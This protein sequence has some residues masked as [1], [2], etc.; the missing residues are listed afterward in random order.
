MKRAAISLYTFT[1]L[2]LSLGSLGFVRASDD[3]GSAVQLDGPG[4][5]MENVPVLSQKSLP[6]CYAFSIAELLQTW[7]CS[8]GAADCKSAFVSPI[9][10]AVNA[11]LWEKNH[12]Q[13]VNK[14][15]ALGTVFWGYNQTQMKTADLVR[16][17][18]CSQQSWLSVPGADN[19]K[20][21]IQALFEQYRL[22]CIQQVSLS[23]GS[24]SPNLASCHFLNGV[25]VSHESFEQFAREAQV[26]LLRDGLGDGTGHPV[27][28]MQIE[29]AF[30]TADP[31]LLIQ[32]QIAVNC[33]AN[34]I[35]MPPM[36]PLDFYQVQ[37]KKKNE[38]ELERKSAAKKA[39]DSEF[40]KFG[41]KGQPIFVTYCEDV[42]SKGRNFSANDFEMCEGAHASLIIGRR[43][44][45]NDPHTCQYLVRNSNGH[46]CNRNPDSLFHYSPD[47]DC[48]PDKG[49][50]WIDQD[51]MMNATLE[52]GGVENEGIGGLIPDA[53]LDS[54]TH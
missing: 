48:D 2:I 20:A 44:S 13:A 12:H 34:S 18:Y 5:S 7:R 14:T 35:V 51:V 42:L 25:P 21:D 15:G 9:P 1:F 50:Y 16:G 23:G 19:L 3:C 30:I 26:C 47:W 31:L 36:P 39:I 49:D 45:P 52:V 27:D 54:K 11:E 38:S 29:N 8:H 32:G 40:N 6:I 10:I 43:R 46:T 41:K 37:P 24:L 33:S 53:Y 28:L 17:P 4:G 22:H